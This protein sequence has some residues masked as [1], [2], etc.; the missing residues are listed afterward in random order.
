MVKTV[1]DGYHKTIITWL[2][3][4]IQSTRNQVSF[5]ILDI[6]P[7]GKNGS[8]MPRVKCKTCG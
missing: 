8:G 1:F 6:G 7:W 5:F 3:V 4:I 2:N